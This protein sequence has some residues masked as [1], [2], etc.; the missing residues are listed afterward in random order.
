MAVSCGGIDAGTKWN[1]PFRGWVIAADWSSAG[2]MILLSIKRSFILRALSSPSRGY[3]MASRTRKTRFLDFH[4]TIKKFETLVSDIRAATISHN[5]MK[6]K[7]LI[8][9]LTIESADTLKNEPLFG[10]GGNEWQYLYKAAKEYSTKIAYRDLDFPYL[11]NGGRCVLCMQVLGDEAQARL[12]RFKCFME[13]AITS[14]IEQVK[15]ILMSN[16]AE[17]NTAT[18]NSEL[19]KD[20]IEEVRIIDDKVASQIEKCFELMAVRKQQMINMVVNESVVSIDP[21]GEFPNESIITYAQSLESQAQALAKNANPNQLCSLKTQIAELTA[22]KN[23]YQRKQVVIDYIKQVRLAKLYDGCIESLSIGHITRKG[24][25]IISNALSG[26][27]RGALEIELKAM[28]ADRIPINWKLTGNTGET[29]HKLELNSAQKLIKANLSDILS[30]GE[31]RIIALAGFLAELNVT[32]HESTIIFDDPVC[33]LDHIW[34]EKVARRLVECAKTKQV[35]VFTHDIVFANDLMTYC[36]RENVTRK[37]QFVSAR[38]NHP[39][40]VDSELPWK[41]G[42]HKE[43][44]DRLEKACN[45]ANTLY[46]TGKD[47]EYEMHVKTIYSGLRATWERVLEDVALCDT[48]LRHRDYIKVTHFR[49]VSALELADCTEFL[50]AHNKCSNIIDGHDP[51]RGRAAPVPTPS[52]IEQDIKY[53][54]D[55][56]DKIKSKQKAIS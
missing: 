18:I 27:L 14:Q 39:G 33:S 13:N 29:L 25:D 3:E 36:E 56:I 48:V 9:A 26:H 24:K 50:S 44:I 4:D 46:N 19:W 34:R 1:A 22:K 2:I 52:E 45:I 15:N 35:V 38:G 49:K 41:A 5:I 55:W 20:V 30:E 7:D 23:L 11:E 10:I 42:R 6:L 47:E 17:L 12:L 32:G 31:Q 43:R 28:G 53:L 54:K 16:I 37:D 8:K 21:L 40:F 51:S